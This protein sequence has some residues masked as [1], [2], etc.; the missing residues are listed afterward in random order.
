MISYL[1]W[2]IIELDF[3]YLT[4]LTNSGVWYEVF[5]NELIYS[6]LSIE[7]EV[8][9][10]IYH[11]RTENSQSLFGFIEKWEKS[12]FS[13]L[14]KISWVWWKVAMLILWLWTSRLIEA[15]AYED[16]KTI[17]SIKWIGKKMAEKIVL[18]LKDKDFGININNPK[19]L[20][21]NNVKSINRDLFT[22]IKDTLVNMWYTP[23]DVESVLNTLPDWMENA[24]DIIPYVIKELS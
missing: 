6:K 19:D 24:G 14:I 9:M 23:K 7:D 20:V 5:I 21:E 17:E 1:K 22:S 12:I 10:F 13:E 8:E 2:K 4:I 3:S 11:H 18:E 15:I 16:K